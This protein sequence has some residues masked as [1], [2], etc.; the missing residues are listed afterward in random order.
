M[1]SPFSAAFSRKVPRYTSYPTAT[2]SSDRVGPACHTAW[3]QRPPRSA[4]VSLYLHIPYC[5]QLCWYC[6]CHLRVTRDNHPLVRY[7]DAL[8]AKIGTVTRILGEVPPVVGSF[9]AF[10]RTDN[11]WH[12]HRPYVGPRRYIMIDCMVDAATAGRELARHRFS[13]Q[14]KR[15]LPW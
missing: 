9:V 5:R 4:A 8:L 13:A 2:Q 3:L 1:G 11:S 14:A 12:G 15:L 6:G 10:R 7:R